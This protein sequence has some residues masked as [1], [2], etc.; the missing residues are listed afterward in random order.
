MKPYSLTGVGL[1]CF[2]FKVDQNVHES[3]GNEIGCL[4]SRIGVRITLS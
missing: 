3:Y 1:T 2:W 4:F